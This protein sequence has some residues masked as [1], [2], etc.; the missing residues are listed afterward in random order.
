[1]VFNVAETVTTTVHHKH[2]KTVSMKGEKKKPRG[3]SNVGRKKEHN[4]RCDVYI[5]QWNV[6]CI[7]NYVLHRKHERAC[8]WIPGRLSFDLS[9]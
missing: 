3:I 7:I 5:C 2:S 8:G 4:L 1:M 6:R 9:K